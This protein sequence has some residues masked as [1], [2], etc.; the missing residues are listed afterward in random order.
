[1]SKFQW[2]VSRR[3]LATVAVAA[4][5]FPSLLTW[6]YFVV[7]Q[8]HSTAVQQAV[9]TAGKVLQFGLPLLWLMAVE[10]AERCIPRSSSPKTWGL[11]FSIAVGAVF[12]L[13]VAAAIL[14]GYL[15]WLHSAGWFAAAEAQIRRKALAFGL[16]TPLQFAAVGIF[17]ALVHSGLEEYYWRWFVFGQLRRLLPLGGATALASLAFAAHHWIVLGVYFGAFSPICWLM[18]IAVAAGG[19]VWCGLYHRSGSL[20]GP[21]LG[22]ALIDAAIFAVGLAVILRS[23]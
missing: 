23:A 16:R 10:P 8:G 1:M 19:A 12:G 3:A 15:G 11:R 20:L 18:T 9:Y 5:A 17:Y 21:W 13:L 6:L 2:H 7:L 14:A 4:M 22:H